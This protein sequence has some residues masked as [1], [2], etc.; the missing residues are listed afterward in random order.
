MGVLVLHYWFRFLGDSPLH[1]EGSSDSCNKIFVF[2][3]TILGETE[4][5]F[6]PQVDVEPFTTFVKI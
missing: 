1:V 5:G 3:I 6:D 4:N 2:W